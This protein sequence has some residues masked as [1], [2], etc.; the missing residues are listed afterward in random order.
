MKKQHVDYRPEKAR[1]GEYLAMFQ[2]ISLLSL[3]GL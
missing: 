1:F 2:G 3:L